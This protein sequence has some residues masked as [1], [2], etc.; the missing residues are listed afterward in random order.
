MKTCDSSISAVVQQCKTYSSSKSAFE[1]SQL[2]HTHYHKHWKISFVGKQSN[3]ISLN[4]QF[5]AINMTKFVQIYSKKALH[6]TFVSASQVL[7]QSGQKTFLVQLSNFY[8]KLLQVSIKQTGQKFQGWIYQN[9]TGIL[10]Y[11]RPWVSAHLCSPSQILLISY[12]P[13]MRGISLIACF[14]EET[15]HDMNLKHNN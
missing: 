9:R 14:H 15:E 8:S 4:T 1:L 12:K 6:L 2:Q 7:K 10:G 13:R 5:T 11:S 3:Q